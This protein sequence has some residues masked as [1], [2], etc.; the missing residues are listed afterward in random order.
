MPLDNSLL[1]EERLLESLRHHLEGLREKAVADFSNTS[2]DRELTG[3]RSDP[4]YV[5]FGFDSAEYALIRLMGRMSIS[6]GRRLGEIYDKI[7]RYMAAARF[8]LLPNQVA[9][10][11]G[12]LELD[13]GLRVSD[14]NE[15]NINHITDVAEKHLPNLSIEE[16][17]GIEIR[18]NFNPND[19]SRLRKDV[20]MVNYLK[21]ERLLPI[22]LVFSILSPRQEAIARLER[23]GWNFLMGEAAAAFARDLL[24]LDL[25]KTLN[26]PKVQEEVN[27]RVTATMQAI[28]S[29]Q[30]FQH[31]ASKY[32]EHR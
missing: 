28:F 26:S 22:Y 19:S 14:L 25:E 21:E 8:D 24:G 15:A 18:Y 13:I 5:N 30:A 9:P 31:I 11:L 17:I 2:F 6:I 29:S 20:D 4:V 16:G 3:L 23:A 12:N 10:K 32:G 27:R 7:P 1:L